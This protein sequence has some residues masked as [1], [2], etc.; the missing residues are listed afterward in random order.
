MM[1]DDK[2]FCCDSKLRYIPDEYID[3]FRW[4]DGDG[5][6]AFIKEVIETSPELDWDLYRQ[7]DEIIREKMH[8]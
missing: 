8:V 5:K 7:K 2:C 6:E 3:N 4:R 1:N